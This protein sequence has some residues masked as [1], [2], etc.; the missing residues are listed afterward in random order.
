V[1]EQREDDIARRLA[2]A[3]QGSATVFQREAWL[4]AWYETIGRTIG[5]PLLVT[6]NDGAT[7]DLAAMLPLVRRLDGRL[8]IIEF[9]GP[10]R[11][12]HE[13]TIPGGRR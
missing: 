9:A 11:Q 1:V 12:R 3:A 2:G 8:R 7:G 4:R 6:V 10:W 5:S 13:C